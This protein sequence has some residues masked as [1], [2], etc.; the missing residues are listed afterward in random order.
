[1]GWLGWWAGGRV[2]E[3][4]CVCARAHV[5]VRWMQVDAIADN[6]R[7]LNPFFKTSTAAKRKSL[8]RMRAS[9]SARF[10][11]H[12]MD[13]AKFANIQEAA[14]PNARLH[15]LLHFKNRAASN[16]GLCAADKK[17]LA[18]TCFPLWQSHFLSSVPRVAQPE[19]ARSQ[20]NRLA[21]EV[22][23]SEAARPAT[24]AKRKVR[25]TQHLQNVVAVE[26]PAKH[27]VREGRERVK[28]PLC[29]RK[30]ADADADAEPDLLQPHCEAVLHE[31]LHASYW[32]TFINQQY[33]QVYWP[34]PEH[35]LAIMHSKNRRMVVSFRRSI[36]QQDAE[37]I[38]AAVVKRFAHGMPKD[39]AMRY[40]DELINQC[41]VA[42]EARHCNS[43]F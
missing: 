16:H 12:D 18:G 5:Y 8:E 19:F 38:A 15:R 27:T 22:A 6:L 9:A 29:V 32:R 43:V 28:Q 25:E 14:N 1:M 36:G 21:S 13:F 33:V 2:D 11:W 17:R 41:C 40:R 35:C 37:E 31:G 10:M 42:K 24:P 39:E 4:S 34:H 23:R 20:A 30:R 3:C 7:A 26:S